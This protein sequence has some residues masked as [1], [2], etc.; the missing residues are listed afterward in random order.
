MSSGQIPPWI[1][2]QLI[3]LQQTQQSLQSIVTQRQNLEIEKRETEKAL[4]ELKKASDMDAVFKHAGTILVKSTK[5]EMIDELEERQEMTKTRSTVLTKQEDRVKEILKEQEAK[6]TEMMKGRSAETATS[7]TPAP[8]AE[9][10]P[11]K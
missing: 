8:P 11:R 7:T 2:E 4:D 3:K 10:N 6:V 5:Q 1:Q 9:E